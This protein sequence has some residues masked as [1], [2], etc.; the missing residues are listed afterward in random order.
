MNFALVVLY[1]ETNININYETVSS[2]LD[3]SRRN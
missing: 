1:K 3:V 2:F